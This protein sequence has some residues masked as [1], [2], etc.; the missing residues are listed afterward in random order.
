MKSIKKKIFS[1]LVLS[2][3]VNLIWEVSHSVL[4]DWN[5]LP[6]YN[7]VYFYIT[8]ILFATFGDLIALTVIFLI[9]SLN[10]KGLNWVKTPSQL[11]YSLTVI[12]GL[13]IA[14]FIELRAANLGKWH[15]SSAMPTIFGIGLT[16][17][18]QLAITGLIV[19][20]LIK[21]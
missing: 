2:Y 9:I 20:W 14:I 15:Y 10:N 12:M 5:T 4:Y 21:D 3:A 13:L 11:D 6:L 7:E 1:F 19:L 17:L 16:P 18:V 8:K